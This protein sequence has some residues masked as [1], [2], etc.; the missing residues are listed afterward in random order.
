MKNLRIGLRPGHF[1]LNDGKAA[2]C[3]DHHGCP[4]SD[5]IGAVEV[6]PRDTNI[7]GFDHWAA[8]GGRNEVEVEVQWDKRRDDR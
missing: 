5:L 8:K 1:R 2:S 4:E 3:V 6:D 7:L